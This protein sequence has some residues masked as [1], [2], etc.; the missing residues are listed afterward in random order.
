MF[1]KGKTLIFVNL[2]TLMSYCIGCMST[3]VI[4]IEYDYLSPEFLEKAK[5]LPYDIESLTFMALVTFVAMLLVNV[6]L[7]KKIN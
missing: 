3:I 5:G 1:S 6:L 2:V 4:A 7:Y